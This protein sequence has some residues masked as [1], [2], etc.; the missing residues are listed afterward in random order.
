MENGVVK[1]FFATGQSELAAGADQ[2]LAQVLEGAKAGKTVTVSGFV[3][4]T[5]N[6]AQ[7]EELAKHRASVVRDHL[8]S[9]GVPEDRIELK[10]PENIDAGAGVQARRVEVFLS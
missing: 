6:A 3:D 9:L 2:A 5:G 8:V 7:N 10:K 4:S 1:F